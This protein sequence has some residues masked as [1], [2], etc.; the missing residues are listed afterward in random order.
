[1]NYDKQYIE[2][3]LNRFLEGESTIA[4][5]EILARYFATH[6]VDSNWEP[7]KQMF[8]YFE[9]GM[10][11]DN[12]LG[13]A[14]TNIIKVNWRKVMGI[15]ASVA[16]MLG[17]GVTALIYNY[18]K[19]AKQNILI[20]PAVPP[21]EV[22]S[23]NTSSEPETIKP[24][25]PSDGDIKTIKRT[26]QRASSS[27]RAAIEIEIEIAEKKYAEQKAEEM[28]WVEDA[29]AATYAQ[30]EQQQLELERQIEREYEQTCLAQLPEEPVIPVP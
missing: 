19:P 10:S 24:C 8:A 30:A 12:A 7:Y 27:S 13:A 15:A 3:L 20:D 5:E 22:L 17:I 23:H 4:E 25:D 26:P 14:S 11:S 18:S 1:M 2:Q 6:T 9:S 16:I 29:I 21:H 28:Q